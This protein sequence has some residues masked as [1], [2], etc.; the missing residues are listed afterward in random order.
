MRLLEEMLA[1]GAGRLVLAFLVLLA[2]LIPATFYVAEEDRK[3][4]DAFAVQHAC[5][6]VGE[7]S[8]STETAVGFGV[9]A[10]GKAG[11]V[12]TTTSTPSKTGWLCDDGI[13]YWR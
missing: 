8:G 13:T 1:D 4:W 10:N 7:L 9:T 2:L 6:K 12:V 11:Q 5:K 3:Q